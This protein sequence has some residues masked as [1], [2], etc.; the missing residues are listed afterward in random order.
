MK[1]PERIATDRAPASIGPYSQAMATETMVFASGQIALD[2]KTGSMVGTSAAEQTDQALENLAAILDAAGTGLDRVVKTTIFL[3]DMND[4]GAVNER[5]AAH[6][7]D[8]RPARA[9][10]AVAALPKGALVEIEA[11]AV[12]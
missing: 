3:V 11:T 5:Y 7:G 9:T 8:H 4:F 2:P 10:I 1:K 12:R 6:F